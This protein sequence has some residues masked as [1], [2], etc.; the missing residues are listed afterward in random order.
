MKRL[1]NDRAGNEFTLRYVFVGSFLR[2]LAKQ[3]GEEFRV[4]HLFVIFGSNLLNLV[5]PFDVGRLVHVGVV[6]PF[7]LTNV[8]D[9]LSNGDA[10]QTTTQDHSTHDGNGQRRFGRRRLKIDAEKTVLKRMYEDD[11]QI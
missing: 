6:E 10:E 9:G 8:D 1:S 5:S 7:P 11:D 2:H 3:G 4:G